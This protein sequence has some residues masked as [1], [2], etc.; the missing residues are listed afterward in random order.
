MNERRRGNANTRLKE[1]EESSFLPPPL[2]LFPNF[3]THD[4]S[5]ENVLLGGGKK[6]RKES[7]SDGE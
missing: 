2:S 6:V 5:R 3:T 1:M 4:C 7:M